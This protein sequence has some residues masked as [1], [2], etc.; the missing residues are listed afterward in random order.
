[1]YMYLAANANA[2]WND[3]GTLWAFKSSNA[4]I[5]DYGDLSG[6][7]SVAG[8][9][10]RVPVEIAK[11]DQTAL[12]NW[13][14]ANNVFQFI[15]VEDIAYDRTTEVVYL[16]DTGEPRAIPN[17]ATG[18]LGRGP[19]GTMGPYP[20]GRIFEMILNEDDPTQVDSLSILIDAD[21][22][23]YANPAALHNPD[24]LETTATSL[25]IQEDTGSHN[26]FALGAGPAAR[27]WQYT[28]ATGEL[29][30]VLEVDQS[31]DG[32]PGYD[33]GG[34]IGRA[35]AWES[36]GIVDASSIWGPG[37]FLLDVQAGS[38]IP[39]NGGWI[40]RTDR[41]PLR[42]GG[43][44]ATAGSHPRRLIQPNHA[45]HRKPRRRRFL[46][47][48]ASPEP[49]RCCG[50]RGSGRCRPIFVDDPCERVARLGPSSHSHNGRPMHRAARLEVHDHRARFPAKAVKRDRRLELYRRALRVA[51]GTDSNF[52]A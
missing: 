7:Q 9:F 12:E 38:L 48:G 15:R 13:S 8:E 42:A 24:N 37:W 1:M 4:S 22:L 17:A 16:A 45:S 49:R 27:V 41:G 10:I 26:Q 19:S 2:V 39:R 47:P 40:P 5:N 30:A 3:Q 29:N 43:W 28:I 32:T 50:I 20:N 36:S 34:G 25:L 31:L 23:G 52:R 18:R 14:N 21:P 33:L 44:T 11:G 51:G 35:G 6:S 46:I